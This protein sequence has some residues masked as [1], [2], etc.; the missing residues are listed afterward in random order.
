MPC[1]GF[2]LGGIRSLF[3]SS[4]SSKQGFRLIDSKL[5]DCDVI[6]AGFITFLFGDK[7]VMTWASAATAMTS[8]SDLTSA[9]PNWVVKLQCAFVGFCAVLFNS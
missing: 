3:P 2:V 4:P 6:T 5:P 1:S 7:L 9:V 8:E